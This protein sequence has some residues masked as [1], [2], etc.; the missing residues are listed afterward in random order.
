MPIPGIDTEG[1]IFVPPP[2]PQIMVSDDRILAH[3]LPDKPFYQ[4]GETVFVEVFLVDAITKKPVHANSTHAK[5]LGTDDTA[6]EIF[7][8][9]AFIDSF[10]S[11]AFRS[12][13]R[14]L[15]N[16]TVVF[17]DWKIPASQKGGEYKIRVTPF[18]ENVPVSYRKIRIGS[19]SN[20]DLFV[21][22]DFDK[23]AYS[24]GDE[25][26]AK[27]KVRRPDGERLPVGTSIAYSVSGSDPEGPGFGRGDNLVL[28]RQ[29]E[30]NITFAVPYSD[31]LEALTVSVS[32]Y[33]GYS[34]Q[35][36]DSSP[37]VSSHSVPLIDNRMKV[38]FYPEMT[39]SGLVPSLPNR[40]YF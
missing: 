40:V 29:G 4:P 6:N 10:D 28:D 35:K 21:T 34:Q 12:Q 13:N 24:P 19:I 14:K 39:N 2:P 23:N 5:Q 20:P 17:N 1:E 37:H 26:L 33:L 30:L 18:A 16:G 3:I 15:Y 31:N 25:V 11:V 8:E 9:C 36:S 38:D 7:A 22:V 27:V 32:T